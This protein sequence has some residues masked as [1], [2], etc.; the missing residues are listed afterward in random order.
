MYLMMD[1]N[2]L[3]YIKFLRLIKRMK[4]H[5]ICCNLCGEIIEEQLLELDITPALSLSDVSPNS[6]DL[7]ERSTQDH[8]LPRAARQTNMELSQVTMTSP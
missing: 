6:D 2:K 7:T 5:W 8:S 3:E 1:H 4:L